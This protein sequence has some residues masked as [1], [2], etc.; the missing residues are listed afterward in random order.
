MTGYA[1]YRNNGDLTEP[2]TEIIPSNDPAIRTNPSLRTATI[3]SFPL[4]PEGLTFLIKVEVITTETSTKSSALSIKLAGTPATPLSAP[5]LIQAETDTTRI[6]VQL[7][8]V[9]N[10]GNDPI[11]TY[12][13]QIDNGEGGAFINIAGYTTRS[14]LRTHTITQGISRGK[15]YRIRYRVGNTV[16][17]SGFSDS[18]VAKA[19]TIPDAPP[20]PTLS[21][22]NST[23]IQLNLFESANNQ[24]SEIQLYELWMNTGVN[25]SAFSLIAS[26]T[27]L[28]YD[29]TNLIHSITS[30][31]IYTFKVRA[32]NGIGYSSYSSE[33]RYATARLPDAPIAPTKVGSLSNS[34]HITV[35]WVEAIATEISIN[36]YR[37][38]VSHNADVYT[39]IYDGQ[40]NVLNRQFTYTGQL[41]TGDV[42]SFKVSAMNLNGEGAM[43]P[44][45]NIHACNA[46]SQPEAPTRVT[47]TTTSISLT[48]APPS[49]DGGCSLT[50]YSLLTDNGTGGSVTSEVD[51]LLNSSPETLS[52]IV[53]LSG[54]LTGSWIRFRVTAYNAEGQSTS[55]TV[56]FVL[57]ETPGKPLLAPSEVT[58]ETTATQIVVQATE[59]ISPENG[60]SSITGYEFQV[61]DGSLGD[62]VTVQ[63]GVND[64]TL[65]LKT[66]IT[67][68][69]IKG[70]TYRVRY[71]GINSVGEGIWSDA[72]NII[73]STIPGKPE[74]PQIT[75][76]LNT[77][78]ALAFTA[79]IENGGQDLIGY[80]LYFSNSSTS[81][82]TFTQDINYDGLSMAYSFSTGIVVGNTYGF[83]IRAVNGRGPSDFS[84]IVYA[85]A[86]RKP[87]TPTAPT[88][89]L[90]GSNRTHVKI[91]WA[92]GTS[93]D[94]PVLG[95]RLS[96]DDRGNGE[97]G[98]IYNG[99]GN[100]NVL[101]FVHG[102]LKTGE[103]YQYYVEVLNFNGPSDPSPLASVNVC[104]A[105]SNFISLE[106]VSSTSTQIKIAW[107]PPTDDGG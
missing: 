23:L 37:L 98:V 84:D 99:Y 13:L 81:L 27:T 9:L 40:Y 19:A 86:G 69:I 105:P 34:T 95:Y 57:A 96:A 78:I 29:V 53:T 70:R 83:R 17:W 2:T 4:S 1:V 89:D 6:T 36:N 59:L 41:I 45:L 75:L 21:N 38:Y 11:V 62:F 28:T 74:T 32:K 33:A 16:G 42:Y 20:K 8:E 71:R 82:S 44:A 55:K 106:K 30:G 91:T 64:R 107:Q 63:G 52:K 50:G 51:T 90:S 48:W 85:A 60:G 15:D 22:S 31:T 101:S 61:D 18:L 46:P 97:F 3:T 56:Q 79:V 26:T 25:G 24:G 39:L 94:I 49:S 10:N 5:T 80:E 43:S 47:S 65:A 67:M 68:N 104:E 92:E 72:V 35:A 87:N 58:A 14:L 73:A 66:T 76:A 12:N 77:G 54:S 102:P 103:T 7:S 100:P 88:H 93:L